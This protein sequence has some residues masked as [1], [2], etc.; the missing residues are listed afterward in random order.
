MPRM[1]VA[2]AACFALLAAPACKQ[3]ETQEE[4]TPA[5]STAKVVVE[6]GPQAGG[7]IKLRSNEPRYLNPILETRH[8]RASMLIFE[9]LV[10]LDA[11]LEP[12]PRLATRWEQSPDGKVI[13]FHL[14]PDVKWHDGEPF[15]ARDVAFTFDAIQSLHAPTLWKA[16]MS[17]VETIETPDDHTVVVKYRYAYAPALTSWTMGILPRHLYEG[18][19][20]L[21]APANR[22]PVGT[23]P[24]KLARWEPEK[25]LLLQANPAWWYGRPQIETIELALDVPEEQAIDK[26]ATGEID[27]ARI[28]NM[29]EWLNKAQLPEFRARFEVSDVIESRI[30]LIAWNLQDPLLQD[31]RVRQALTQALNRGRVIEDVLFGQGR[32]LSAPFFPTMFG[33][34][35]SIAPWPFDLDGAAAL[36]DAA[37]HARPAEGARFT[38]D[39]MALATQRSPEVDASMAIFREDL[40]DIGITLAIDYV[41]L[42]EFFQRIEARDFDAVYF[43]WLPDIPDPDPYGLLH[44]SMLGI[45]ANFAGYANPD[46]DA[47][48]DEARATA[49]RAKRKAIY[50]QIHRMVHQELPYTPLYAPYGHYAWNR[51]IRGVSPNDVGSQPRFPGMARWWVMAQQPEEMAPQ[52]VR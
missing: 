13:T 28:D 49:D 30:R 47:L 41:P 29:D 18:Q 46:V 5:P 7:Y 22:E 35:P 42:R 16:Y 31:A 9:G 27:F 19:E 4:P 23:G 26:L 40:A 21:S 25:R 37:G 43:T 20:L 39:L 32:S 44:S 15:T 10:G 33:A 17:A 8:E 24:Y 1:F 48:L 6:T 12:V 2:P 50:Q 34:D 45:G 3:V 36:L 11:R 52:P 51:R 38:I 14:R